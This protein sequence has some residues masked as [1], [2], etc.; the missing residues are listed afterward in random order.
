MRSL[1]IIGGN[2][3][4]TLALRRRQISHRAF[5]SVASAVTEVR[6]HQV[7]GSSG[8][9]GTYPAPCNLF[10]AVPQY[11]VISIFGIRTSCDYASRWAP[12]LRCFAHYDELRR[13]GL[14]PR[15]RCSI[16][17]ARL[18]LY[19]RVQRTEFTAAAQAGRDRAK[20]HS[21]RALTQPPLPW[22]VLT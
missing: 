4:P 8:Q 16:F 20:L 9:V 6:R 18:S 5:K 19:I 21:P 13:T 12:F 2:C 11:I 1:V 10:T 17:R 3:V 14:R 7:I 22:T 15:L